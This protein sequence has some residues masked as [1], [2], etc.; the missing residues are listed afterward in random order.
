MLRREKYLFIRK[1]NDKD[2]ITELC[3]YI[4]TFTYTDKISLVVDDN[5]ISRNANLAILRMV[6][7]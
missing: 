3:T 4:D 7:L 1:S 6:S 5:S 2:M